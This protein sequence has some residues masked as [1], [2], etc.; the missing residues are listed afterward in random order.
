MVGKL[1]SHYRITGRL[2][3]G[4]MGVVY[5]A[6]DEMLGRTVAL[7]FP[8]GDA[9][10]PRQLA[11]EARAASQF[12]H[13]NVAQ[14]YEF[15]ET[16][17]SGPFIAME[18][19]RGRTLHAMLA[20]GPLPPAE[21]VR[22]VRAVAQALEEAHRHQFLH[23][24]I[25]PGNVAVDERGNVKVLDFGLAK[26]L[27]GARLEAGGD[28][29]TRTLTG[30]IR[31][32][33][34]YMSP[35]QARG[36]PLD[37]RSDLFSLGAVMYE[38]LTATRAFPAASMVGALIE[39]VSAQP[40]PPS[41]I[42]PSVPRRLD[43][44]VRRLLAKN[45][46]ERHASATELIADLDGDPAVTRPRARRR[47]RPRVAVGALV[48]LL[49]AAAVWWIPWNR[50]R[51][52]R[53]VERQVAVLP[54]EN[55]TGQPQQAAFCDGLAEIVTGILSQPGVFS[56]AIW[57][58][59]S[60]DVRHYGVETVAGAGRMLH[61][62]LAIGGSVQR[63]PGAPA[64]LITVSVSETAHPHL[65]GSQSVQVEERDAANINAMLTSALVRLLDVRARP[66]A[67]PAQ[68]NAADY[69]RFVAAR[70]YLRQY[71]RGDNLSRAVKELEAI[72][73]S[74]PDYAPAQVALAEACYRMYIGTKKREWLAK[75]DQAV[76]RGAEINENEPGIPLMM[77]RILRA[78]GQAGAAIRELQAA[79]ARDPDD[80]PALLQ[81]AGAYQDANRPA[82]AE[83]TY[84]QATR[85]R[86]SYFPA[87]TNLGIL[88]M[89]QG[90]WQAAE[91]PFTL[92]TRLAPDFADG[93]TNLGYAEY[94]LGRW[95][96]AVRLFSRSIELK[97]TAKAYSNRCG[98]KF[99]QKAIDDAV[100][101]CRK[102]VD[103]Q[104]ADPLFWGNLADALF[105]RGNLEDAAQTYRRGLDEGDKLLAINPANP[106]LMATMA[107]YAIRTGQKQKAL[108]LASRALSQGN[109]VDV[110]YNTGKAYGMA[111]DCARAGVLLQQAFD[112]GYPRQVARRDPDLDR[113]RAAPPACAV[114]PLN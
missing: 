109:S 78:T 62:D 105:E 75:A 6:V 47:L 23:L 44:I 85:L 54:F 41:A 18:L 66:M 28:P 51:T 37:A 24:D 84:Q 57:V 21:A 102:A 79:T 112:K 49:I 33:P 64:W 8:S 94:Y 86:P 95:D 59:P 42:V 106:D 90:K 101:D 17:E 113:L 77:G 82:D 100:A 34:C 35:E 9:A 99:Y 27:P 30:V 38:C 46:E 87:Y 14:I 104:P 58:L 110:L 111:G 76:R 1:V 39:V 61:A 45:R 22:I 96:E 81:L 52:A 88:Y 91:E 19:V 12:N 32:T 69:S 4:G 93:Y 97:P 107:K 55:L 5:E 3:E 74:T 10:S 71:D 16:P 13:P 83:A 68:P 80:M 20:G 60:S 53:P 70:G 11:E 108:D 40:E 2:G 89:S 29:R 98:V 73:T 26:L 36:Q 67:K 25:K 65:L 72:A 114:P 50:F 92:V 63:P 31:G 103:M 48:V 7:K 43:A 15:G 56:N